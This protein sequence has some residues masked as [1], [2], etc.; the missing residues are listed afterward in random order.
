[1]QTLTRAAHR[2]AMRTPRPL[3]L[4]CLSPQGL[5]SQ[6]LFNPAAAA[7]WPGVTVVAAPPQHPTWRHGVLVLYDGHILTRCT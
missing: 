1:M 3:A 7:A 4:A 2:L 6:L 5:L